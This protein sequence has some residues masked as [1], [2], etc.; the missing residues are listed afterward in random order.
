MFDTDMHN[1]FDLG[2][3][4]SVPSNFESI[5]FYPN[6]DIRGFSSLENHLLRKLK[7]LFGLDRGQ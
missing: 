4:S 7:S 6:S 2:R 5:F 3:V 1:I